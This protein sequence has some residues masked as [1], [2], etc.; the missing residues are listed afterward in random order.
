MSEIKKVLIPNEFFTKSSGGNN[1]KWS[2]RYNEMII[3]Y[4]ALIELGDDS[5]RMEHILKG[6]EMCMGV[7]M[8]PTTKLVE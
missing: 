6:Y 1:R 2:A 4:N 7:F 8:P 5:K 3:R